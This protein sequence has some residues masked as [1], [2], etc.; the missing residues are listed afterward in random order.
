MNA[1][2]RS[3]AME[4]LENLSF[5]IVV[6]LTLVAHFSSHQALKHWQGELDGFVSALR[7]YDKGKKRKH[8]FNKEIICDTLMEL[9]EDRKIQDDI[10]DFIA[11]KGLP[12]DDLN[13]D[14][15]KPFVGP[16]ADSILG[17]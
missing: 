6:H 14:T 15:V 4:A 1:R 8:N 2:S 3:E 5:I 12:I 11:A 9:L 10:E 7:R 16:F 17:E 13:F